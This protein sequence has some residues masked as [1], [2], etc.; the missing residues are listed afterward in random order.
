M[1]TLAR[2][3]AVPRNRRAARLLPFLLLVAACW[4]SL[5]TLASPVSPEAPVLVS[6]AP[7]NGQVT[8]PD[9]I[10]L[11]FDRPVPAGLSTIRMTDP[12]KRPVDPGR[13]VHADGRDNTLSVPVPK[14]KYAGTYTIAWS[15]PVKGTDAATGTFTFD[16]ASRSPVQAPPALDARPGV[17]VT[18]AHAVA[19]FLAFAALALLA[20]VVL[21][22]AV[23]WPAGAEST[24]VRRLAAWAW[25]GLLGGTVLSLLTFGPYAAKLPLTD[26]LDGG[27]VSGVLESATGH[28]YLARLLVVAVAGI[29]IAQFLTMAPAESA[30]ERRLRGGT[31]LACTA[32]VVA[33]WSFTGPGSV[34]AG[35]VHL[36]ALA[37]LA[38]ILVVLRR[39]REVADRP[40]ALVV[41]CA[42]LLAV[43]AGA[44]VWQHLGS[45]AGWL[46]A[47]FA[48]LVL[49]LGLLALAGRLSLVQTGLAVAL[50]GVSTALS[51]VPAGPAP[52]PQAPLVR[53]ALSTGALDLAVVPARVGDNQVHVTVLDAKPGTTITAELAPPSGAPVPVSF[54]P[55]EAGHLAGSVTVPS[56][57]PWEL[58]LTARA[59]DGQQEVIYGV[60]EVR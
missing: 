42:G 28:V 33:T 5:L 60:I 32:A 3:P 45:L 53:L 36:T 48:V 30:R 14:Q 10:V 54:A 26:I 8:R 15:V 46:W 41:V 34:V 19:Q 52:A 56:A 20:G 18:V 11:T 22:V 44:E 23:G 49:A 17:V 1:T 51:V 31:V 25:G 9:D 16:L 59:P 50:V 47:G 6:S 43:T 13:P 4:T 27:L 2:P 57:G 39:F 12:Y 38:G 37:V 40:K 21:F 55:A 29:G 24:V 58:A 7:G 35:V